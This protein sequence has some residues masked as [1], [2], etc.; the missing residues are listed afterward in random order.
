[1]AH[2]PQATSVFPLPGQ[3]SFHQLASLQTN[4]LT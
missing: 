3:A 1:M 4:G 2:S